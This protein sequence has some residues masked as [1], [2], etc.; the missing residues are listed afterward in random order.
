MGGST[1]FNNQVT[2]PFNLIGKALNNTLKS[3]LLRIRSFLNLELVRRTEPSSDA[4][5]HFSKRPRQ[6]VESLT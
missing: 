4:T 2:I 3:D 6:Q 5:A 1:Y